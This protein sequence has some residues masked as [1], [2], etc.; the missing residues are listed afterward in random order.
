[1]YHQEFRIWEVNR[2][3]RAVFKFDDFG[4]PILIRRYGFS[5]P[6]YP[7]LLRDALERS[8]KLFP[9]YTDKQ[10]Y[11]WFKVPHKLIKVR[12]HFQLQEHPI[13]RGINRVF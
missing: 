7:I 8:L 2:F 13:A 1:M 9:E 12:M 6:N 11:G 10:T 4:S 5:Q 3:I